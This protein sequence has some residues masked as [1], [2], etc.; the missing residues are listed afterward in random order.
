MNTPEK[1]YYVTG[2]LK[3]E[4]IHC[5]KYNSSFS[6][7]KIKGVQYY[8]ATIHLSEDSSELIIKNK[9]YE[10]PSNPENNKTRPRQFEE[11]KRS[12]DYDIYSRSTKF[13]W[14]K[15]TASCFVEDI[16]GIIFGGYSSRFWA[17]RK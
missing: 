2:K 10:D 15:S 5:L 12:N 13:R 9:V 8:K 1:I 4:K 6:Q 11:T 17:L 16:T 7:L 3:D 14:V